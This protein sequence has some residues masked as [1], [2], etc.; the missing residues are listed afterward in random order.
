LKKNPGIAAVLNFL[1]PGVGS[2]YMGNWLMAIIH[3]GVGVFAS[4]NIYSIHM[5]N[6]VHRES[7][8]STFYLILVALNCSIGAYKAYYDAEQYNVSLQKNVE[9]EQGK[10][11]FGWY[12]NNPPSTKLSPLVWLFFSLPILLFLLA[13]LSF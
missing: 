4:V 5:N 10:E 12:K 2:I 1:L 11:G 8:S 9:A 3:I 6:I 13:Y 7:N